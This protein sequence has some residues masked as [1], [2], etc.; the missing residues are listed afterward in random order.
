MIYVDVCVGAHLFEQ[1]QQNGSRIS[2]YATFSGSS[3]KAFL[4][5]LRN[6]WVRAP[7]TRKGYEISWRMTGVAGLGCCTK[8]R[9]AIAS[10]SVKIMGPRTLGLESKLLQIFGVQGNLCRC[11]WILRTLKNLIFHQQLA[12][13]YRWWELGIPFLPIMIPIHIHP[14]PIIPH[15]FTAWF[16]P[17]IFVPFV[18]GFY[19][20]VFFKVT[21]KTLEH[22]LSVCES[23]WSLG[24]TSSK[25]V[26]KH[27]HKWIDKQIN[28]YI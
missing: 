14:Y 3:P 15:M 5:G 11:E 18:L 16:M 6:A 1:R 19:V 12:E 22:L 28:A 7:W 10:R 23:Q 2:L 4:F 27:I 9:H 24:L 8:P 20:V 26:K 13:F 25:H 17:D 21:W